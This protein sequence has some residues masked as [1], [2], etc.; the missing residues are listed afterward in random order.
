MEDHEP[1]RST[2]ARI[3]TGR[4]HK[5]VM[6]ASAAEAMAIAENE[7]FDLVISDIGLPDSN[8][9]DLFR[10]LQDKLPDVK[11]I[12][13]SGYGMDYD[14]VR[15]KDNGFCAHLT[16][17]VKIQALEEALATTLNLGGNKLI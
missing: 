14:L 7:H 12:A 4:H 6:A 13:L 10:R 17:P 9:Y 1:T 3:L 11:G 16:K 8:G 5:V 2:L 15:S